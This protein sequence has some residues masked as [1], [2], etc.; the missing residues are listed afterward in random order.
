MQHSASQRASQ[1]TAALFGALTGA[2]LILTGCSVVDGPGDEA[3]EAGPLDAYMSALWDGE[4]YTQ[5]QL[6]AETKQTEELIAE[7]MS[8]E[9]FEY[10]PNVQNGGTII[11]SEEGDEIDWTSEEFI[12]QH[13]Y[14][15]VDWPGRDDAQ[16]ED[17]EEYVDP[18]QDYVESLSES[19]Q[20]AY[21]E[22]L[23]GPQ[24]TEEELAAMEDGEAVFEYDWTT[25]GCTGAAQHQVQS[26]SGGGM[27]AYEDPEFTELFES[28]NL[29]YD[30]LWSGDGSNDD[31]LALDRDWADCVADAGHDGFASPMAAQEALTEEYNELHMPDDESGEWQEPSPADVKKFQDR[32]IELALAD[33]EC[34]TQLEYDDR[35]WKIQVELEQ[36]F[37]DAHRAELEA[38]VAKHGVEKKL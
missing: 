7:C 19:E 18:N 4:E 14:G 23:H 11:S 1:R 30:A 16:H 36:E 6:D 13:G 24:P 8:G 33:L 35:M 28:M 37:V 34:K 25:S 2:L 31:I 15:I 26:E 9:G 5:E 22:A 10:V 12:E 29:I 21:V 32:E 38:L 20:T 17:P 27:A 3:S